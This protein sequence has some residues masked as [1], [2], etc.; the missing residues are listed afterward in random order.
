MRTIGIDYDSHAVHFAVLEEEELS[1]YRYH[2]GDTLFDVVVGIQVVLRAHP[3]DLVIVEAPIYIQN[4]KTSF[5]LAQVHTLIRLA[6]EKESCKYEILGVTAWKK[7]TF[8]F[9]KLTKQEVFELMK[10][11]YGEIISD[12]HF[13]D[14][15]AM[16]VAGQKL[17]E[18]KSG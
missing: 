5:K 17:L 7:L 10:T 9:A 4:P 12:T 14:S 18:S 8:G 1:F 15:A 6:C 16:A 13:A 2:V 11:K 3:A